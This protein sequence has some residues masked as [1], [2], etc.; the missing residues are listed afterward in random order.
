M[1]VPDDAH[2]AHL[3]NLY[4]HN[5]ETARKRSIWRWRNLR[6]CQRR[7][8][9][10]GQSDQVIWESPKGQMPQSIMGYTHNDILYVY[11]LTYQVKEYQHFLHRFRF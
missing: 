6:L 11:V 7:L 3:G 4:E 10:L 2:V 5:T 1:F 8:I 9:C